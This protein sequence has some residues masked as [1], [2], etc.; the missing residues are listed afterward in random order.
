MVQAQVKN[1]DERTTWTVPACE[2]KTDA[3]SGSR[4]TEIAEAKSSSESAR[5][6][7]VR[8]RIC[9]FVPPEN[10]PNSLPWLDGV[11]EQLLHA[12]QALDVFLE[13]EI[14]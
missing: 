12:S 7:H 3:Y 9:I 5:S 13:L 11:L 14:C 8:R 1:R 10:G 6:V 2:V 4:T